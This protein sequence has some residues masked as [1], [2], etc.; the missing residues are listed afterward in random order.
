MIIVEFRTSTH[1]SFF[2]Y[3]SYLG[4]GPHPRPPWG[5]HGEWGP[6]PHGGGESTFESPGGG[7]FGPLTPWGFGG[8]LHDFLS[9]SDSN[10]SKF[11]SILELDFHTSRENK[12]VY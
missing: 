6:H 8:V 7:G 9:F 1:C 11:L 2:C 12:N 5:P 10:K 4:F 3:R